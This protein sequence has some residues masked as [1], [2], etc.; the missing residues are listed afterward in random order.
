MN[1]S[2]MPP[3]CAGTPTITVRDNRGLEVRTLR[4]NRAVAGAVAAQCVEAL[5]YNALDQLV[6]SQDPRFFGGSTL[7]ARYT[8]ALTGQALATAS[9]D[10]G[11]SLACADIAGRPFWQSS[12]GRDAGQKR[13]NEIAV[14]QY[15][16][17][18]G[19]PA[20]RDRT[21]QSI[22]EEPANVPAGSTDLW[23]YGDYGGPAGA[24]YDPH[25]ASDPR[26]ANQRGQLLQHFDTA[27]LLDMS[28]L[29]YGV[30]GD[31]GEPAAL[32]QDRF[33]LAATCDPDNTWDPADTKPPFAR[34]RM[35]LEPGD[36]YSTCWTLNALSQVLVRTDARG[37]RQHT[38]YDRAGRKYSVSVTP[39]GG[40]LMPVTAAVTYTAAGG[41]DTR[42]DAN[43]IQVVHAYEP[44]ATQRLVSMTASRTSAAGHAATTTLQAL[45]Y[46]YDGVGNVTAL[47]DAGAG[48]Q[49]GFFRNRMTTPDRAYAYDA[50]YRLTSASGRENYVDDTP[51]GT[52]WPGGAFS[53]SST[54][55]YRPYTRRYTYD[56]GGNLTAI[57]CADWTGA[58]PPTRNL[59]VGRASNRAVCTANGSG[60][61]PENIDDYFD[62]A[63]KSICMD[64]NVNQPM[65]WTPL[66]RLYCV[67]TA[68]RDPGQGQVSDWSESDREQYAYDGDGQRV[69]KYGSSKAGSI[70]N[71]T[72]TRY[73]PGLELRGDTGTGERL[74][75]IVLDD[76]ARVLN[77]PDGT[78]Q[79]ADMPNLQLRY[80]Y[81]DRQDSCS[82]ET[83]EDGNV[84]TREEYYPYGG[85]A[86]LT[87]R[88]DSE[89]KYK[90]I[91][92]CGKE[93]DTTGFYYYG[94]RYY[95]PWT[96]RWIS[97]DPAGAIDGLNLYR[98]MGNNPAT[99]VDAFGAVGEE[100]RSFWQ[101]VTGAFTSCFTRP[102]ASRVED[103]DL[104]TESPTA[105]LLDELDRC[106]GDDDTRPAWA[107]NH[108]D[109][110]VDA[111][112]IQ[113]I[114]DGAKITNVVAFMAG[115]DGRITSPR[116]LFGPAIR[117]FVDFG[118]HRPS[119]TVAGIPVDVDYD[120][121]IDEAMRVLSRTAREVDVSVGKAENSS[122][123]NLLFTVGAAED[124][125]D[126]FH[127]IA[128]A[129]RIPVRLKDEGER[130]VGR[131]VLGSKQSVRELDSFLMH[132][133]QSPELNGQWFDDQLQKAKNDHAL[134]SEW[135]SSLSESARGA[136]AAA[137]LRMVLIH[138]GG[139]AIFGLDHPE[140]YMK[141]MEASVRMNPGGV[142]YG[143]RTMLSG[144]LA[145]S[146]GTRQFFI[147][148]GES[149]PVMSSARSTVIKKMI[150][151]KARGGPV[152]F[153]FSASEK[154]SIV[155]AY[156]YR[157]LISRHG[158]PAQRLLVRR[159]LPAGRA[160][161]A[162]PPP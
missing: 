53:P 70:W 11:T 96:G 56:L 138:E 20:R 104:D 43:R 93:R 91:R 156:K 55:D 80:R 133:L 8:P 149:P 141:S 49:V 23:W 105:S 147:H 54:P 95:Q 87:S 128:W 59:A 127:A 153:D 126:G 84:I 30:Q 103:A 52:D 159:P 12:R 48:A 116:A 98:A 118:G 40:G 112:E 79:P 37:H 82:L 34:N 143:D 16:D 60:P 162:E 78:G 140:D 65:Y 144:L 115:L 31:D 72:D 10:G 58:T 158:D 24:A 124:V 102:S 35:L 114:V 154:A 88:T 90:F 97:P 15:Y 109:I 157:Q 106:T 6:A 21:L 150:A 68:Y 111:A 14:F 77:W 99:L 17:A 76:G 36:P 155:S 110:A 26:N 28:A 83:D 19:R 94:L 44:Q 2:S 161:V 3:L 74:E 9:A 121:Q 123:A 139:H 42:S 41:I 67:V 4:Y 107:T 13:D 136:V 45:T 148:D 145:D 63:G 131:I 75:V 86:V 120:A 62:G 29:G 89:V 47:S 73:L 151:Q 57:G 22:T 108:E 61:T 66:H 135:A 134:I 129:L 142:R 7:N 160:T 32:R 69:R 146:H 27:G 122:D 130:Y 50:L 25:D 38:A 125:G 18:L 101:S 100:P 152:D 92:Y 71:H 137:S 119:F 1:T 117:Y 39:A 81:A 46:T 113:R 85:T 64:G 33:F 132:Y 5:A 51:K